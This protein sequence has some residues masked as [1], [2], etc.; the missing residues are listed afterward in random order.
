MSHI[1]EKT[2]PSGV[3]FVPEWLWVDAVY[4]DEDGKRQLLRVV[5]FDDQGE[6]IIVYSKDLRPAGSWML[7]HG[8]YQGLEASCLNIDGSPVRVGL[9]DFGDL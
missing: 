4:H 3:N 8:G 7:D 9:H 6:P 2:W 5:A 1:T